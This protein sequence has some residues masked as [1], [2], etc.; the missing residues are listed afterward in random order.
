MLSNLQIID[1]V[2]VFMFSFQKFDNIID[3]ISV[4]SF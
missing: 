2:M 1:F 3:V 4:H